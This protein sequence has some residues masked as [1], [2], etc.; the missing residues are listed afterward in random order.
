M[1]AFLLGVAAGFF[2]KDYIL[3]GWA[4]VKGKI[5]SAE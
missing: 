5:S 4:W 3:R 1:L 2:G